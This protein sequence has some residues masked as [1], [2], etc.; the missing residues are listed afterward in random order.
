LISPSGHR[1][2]FKYDGWARIIEAR[3]DSGIV[4]KYSYSPEGLLETESDG[5]RILYRFGYQDLLDAPGYEK[6]LMTSI[7]DGENRLLL[8]NVYADQS[9]VSQQM[10]ASG[11]TYRYRYDIDCVGN[12]REATV[13]LPDGATK[14]FSFVTQKSACG[15]R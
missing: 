10:L 5:S 9:R 14:H 6:Y 15:S 3:D 12:M 7:T 4:R 1:L 8:R 13:T 11:E 2:T